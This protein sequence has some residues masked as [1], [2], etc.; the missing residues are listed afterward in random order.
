MPISR[1]RLLTYDP[2][3]NPR[4]FS[5]INWRK[6]FEA[7]NQHL[8]QIKLGSTLSEHAYSQRAEC[9]LQQVLTTA[10]EK[11]TFSSLYS[12]RMDKG[13]LVTANATGEL[14]CTPNNPSGID[15]VCHSEDLVE[16]FGSSNVVGLPYGST[17]VGNNGK[18]LVQRPLPFCA[19]TSERDGIYDA[20]GR[21]RIIRLHN[22]PDLQYNQ[23]VV[24]VWA[25]FFRT[26]D[27]KLKAGYQ[28]ARGRSYANSL[29]WSQAAPFDAFNPNSTS[30]LQLINAP[31]TESGLVY[32]P[33]CQVLQNAGFLYDKIQA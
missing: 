25:S 3:R 22:H 10:Y 5:L 6:S 32:V 30:A 9:P 14:P 29:A 20:D 31:P 23:Y 15:N 18:S 12:Y 16:V 21:R 2:V 27:P 1:R 7:V 13:I 24:D 26:F 11:K 4:T 17:P 19:V 33:Q 28:Q 8:Y